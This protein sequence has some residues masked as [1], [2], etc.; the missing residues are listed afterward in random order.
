MHY[1]Q[2]VAP[3]LD[4]SSKGAKGK[5]IRGLFTTALHTSLLYAMSFVVRVKAQFLSHSEDW[6]GNGRC[7]GSR[8]SRAPLLQ[9]IRALFSS[10]FFLFAHF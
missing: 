6:D 3:P 10:F 2:S 5:V 9:E 7:W 8:F 4:I 1:R